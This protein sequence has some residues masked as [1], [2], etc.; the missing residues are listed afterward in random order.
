MSV[1]TTFRAVASEFAATS[2]E[3][4]G[5]WTDIVSEGLDAATFGARMNLACARLVAHE[6]TLEARILAG[7]DGVGAVT[8]IRTGDLSVS[9]GG[10]TATGDADDAF[11][12]TTHG[13]A[14]LAIRNSR[15]GVGF[16]LLT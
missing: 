12:Q 10:S 15:A 14:F 9:Y 2:D 3:V 1:L 5:E 8:S 11:R 13:L 6:L 16:G 7:A 4:V